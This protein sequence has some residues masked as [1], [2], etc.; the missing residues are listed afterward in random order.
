[1]VIAGG[2]PVGLATAIEL[3]VHGVASVVVEP[4]GEVSWLRPRAKTTS[5]RTMEHFRRWGIA[6]VLRAQAPM[7][8][9]WS[10]EVVFCT[11]L[12]G[13]EVTRI[14]HCMGLD[15]DHD[16]LVAEGGQ[17][18]PQP[19]VELVMRNKIN[20]LPQTELLTG[21]RVRSFNQD[22]GGVDTVIENASGEARAI[23]SAYLVGCDGARSVVREGIGSTLAG[24][25]DG[26]PNFNIVFR[27]PT[28]A[29]RL[30][31]GNAVH[32]WVL[33][34]EQPGVLGRLDLTDTWWAI[35]VGLDAERGDADPVA[36]V[37]CLI[38]DQTG[39]VPIE[40]I[41]TDPW[42][43][44]ML[45]ADQYSQGRV[46]LAGD[47]AHQNPPW[48]GHGFNTGIGD[49]V[50]LGWKLAAVLNGWAST[51]LLAT[52]HD[53]RRPIAADTIAAAA[54]NMATLAPELS[55][56][57][58]F[59]TDDE[60]STIRPTVEK[61]I[62]QAKDSEFHSLDLV[63][64]SSYPAS[65][66]VSADSRPDP[67]EPPA[68]PGSYRP[69]AA[70]GNRLPHTWLGPDHSL[71]DLLGPEFS[72]VGDLDTAGATDL[73]NTA[74]RLAIPLTLVKLTPAQSQRLFQ[75]PLVLVRPDQH[76]AWR[77]SHT[78]HPEQLLHKITGH[79]GETP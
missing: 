33:N 10:D 14:R 32:Y 67:D 78:P 77:G 4:R 9:A 23:H 42:R 55:D 11:T 79:H 38:G 49:A 13:R 68:E 35:A 59:G 66:I 2:G 27:S 20:S 75:A 8:Q 45:L 65:P 70:P 6:Q 56:P 50:N 24:S 51:S 53:E 58:L 17:Q 31:H 5:A 40:I 62:H 21:W 52:Y 47:A 39:S 63:L 61:V 43:A 29:H 15:L 74:R 72:L 69:S 22:H 7:P 60:F 73:I 30:R 37:R 19:L 12:L 28:L 34:P 1:V 16:E 71:Y 48:G 64:G 46:F 54:T 25:A 26:R 76:V 44:R 18:A 36:A 57:R 41:A 3:S